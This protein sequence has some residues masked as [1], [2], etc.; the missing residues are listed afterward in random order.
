MIKS[1]NEDNLKKGSYGLYEYY[2]NCKSLND[3]KLM[4]QDL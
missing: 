2:I 3:K 1:Y 4:E